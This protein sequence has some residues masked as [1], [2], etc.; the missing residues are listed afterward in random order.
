MIQK[1][2]NSLQT[3][4]PSCL[5]SVGKKE[6]KRIVPYFNE[7]DFHAVDKALVIAYC[8]CYSILLECIV[9]INEEGIMLKSTKDQN[10]INPY[11]SI[12][13]AQLD[14][15][16]KLSGELLISPASRKRLKIELSVGQKT[17]KE[18]FFE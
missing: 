3:L 16:K 14:I 6:Y 11:L 13:R 12:Y 8:Q 9:K 15:L 4:P 5:S 10:L 1:K 2:R 18:D 7:I 17:E